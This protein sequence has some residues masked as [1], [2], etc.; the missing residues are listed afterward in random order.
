MSSQPSE[1]GLRGL[2]RRF[3][4]S[5]AVK[6]TSRLLGYDLVRRHYYSAIPDL[7]AVPPGAWTKESDLDG[8]D[9]DPAAQLEFVEAELAGALAEYAPPLEPTGSPRDFYLANTFY[10]QVDAETLYAMVRRFSP[11]R[12]VELGSGMSTLVIAD[13]LRA[14]GATGGEHF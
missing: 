2:A 7:V 14:A 1:A 8:L 11:P 13:A 10:E 6:S 4:I 12:V 3:G 9:F 5:G